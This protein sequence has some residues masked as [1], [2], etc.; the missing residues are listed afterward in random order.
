MTLLQESKS[1]EKE[2][3]PPRNLFELLPEKSP[4][5]YADSYS[6]KKKKKKAVKDSWFHK[7]K[8]STYIK[9]VAE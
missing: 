8:G 9:V 5:H 6:S 4:K 1:T 3:V 2:K 7:Y